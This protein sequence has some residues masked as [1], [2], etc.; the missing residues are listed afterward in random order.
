MGEEEEGQRSSLQGHE[1]EYLNINIYMTCPH[2]L[3]RHGAFGLLNA[4]NVRSQETD[5]RGEGKEAER[6]NF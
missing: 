5:G 2:K 6:R 1:Q 4:H 3:V